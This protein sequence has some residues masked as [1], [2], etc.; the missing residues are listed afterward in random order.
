MIMRAILVVLS[1]TLF[2]VAGCERPDMPADAVEAL[3]SAEQYELL[4]LD[5]EAYDP[6]AD[7]KFYDWK[8]LGRVMIDDPATRTKLNDA[9]RAG[10]REKDI[11]RSACFNPRHGIRVTT[12]GLVTDVVIC[13]ECSS[14]QIYRDGEY[15][16]G[17]AVSYAPAPTFDE[18]LRD[19]GVLQPT[20]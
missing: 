4:S 15:V 17:F 1:A 5:P 8:V 9:L 20:N 14:V 3:A 11:Y 10:A 18:V 2:A 12:D 6:S 16:D 19:R 13:F 7:E